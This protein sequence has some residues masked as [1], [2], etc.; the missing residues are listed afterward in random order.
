M[1]GMDVT[2]IAELELNLLLEEMRECKTQKDLDEKF[3]DAQDCLSAYHN[4]LL[5]QL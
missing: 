4:S 3:E 5:A 1:N 2:R